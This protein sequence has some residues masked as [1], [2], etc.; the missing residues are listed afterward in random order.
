MLKVECRG[1][2]G[3]QTK[4]TNATTIIVY[5]QFENPIAVIV[6]VNPDVTTVVAANDP[7]FNRIT[8]ALGL[9]KVVVNTPLTVSPEVPQDAKLI[10]GPFGVL[11]G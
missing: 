1:R 2:I 7:D 6:E 3:E 10:S 9:N 11:K 4:V 8:H 5:D